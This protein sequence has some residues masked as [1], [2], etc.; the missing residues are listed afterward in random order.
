MIS[1]IRLNEDDLEDLDIDD[2]DESDGY[3]VFRQKFKPELYI[4]S[5]IDLLNKIGTQL[6]PEKY[7]KAPID[8]LCN[9]IVNN[10]IYPIYSDFVRYLYNYNNDFH[11]IIELL[12]YSIEY[13][14]RELGKMYEMKL[15]QSLSGIM[16]ELKFLIYILQTYNS[17]FTSILDLLYTHKNLD[18]EILKNLSQGLKLSLSML[19][20]L[21]ELIELYKDI[22]L[23]ID[24]NQV[25]LDEINP[26][27]EYIGYSFSDKDDNYFYILVLFGRM[28]FSKIGLKYKTDL[29]HLFPNIKNGDIDSLG[30]FTRPN[31]G[32]NII[33]GYGT[34]GEPNIIKYK[35]IFEYI[36]DIIILAPQLIEISK[37]HIRNPTPAAIY[38]V[39]KVLF[40]DKFFTQK[41]I[42]LRG[43]MKL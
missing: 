12:G 10:I 3:Y 38:S 39:L 29:I 11:T 22:S 5:I 1:Y 24:I 21:H 31:K 32:I 37:P 4:K 36:C 42:I 23:P 34:E 9:D 15:I 17:E 7:D 40:V 16:I 26:I 6:T 19:T 13:K 30:R 20:S 14:Q 18:F 28:M 8:E 41:V 35:L 27:L 43:L 25:F 33:F 2:N